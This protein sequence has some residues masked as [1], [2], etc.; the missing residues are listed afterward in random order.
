MK[1]WYLLIIRVYGDFF[2]TVSSGLIVATWVS[3]RTVLGFGKLA[4]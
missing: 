2:V 1:N 3:S 4:L